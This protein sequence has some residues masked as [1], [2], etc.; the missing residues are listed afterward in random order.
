MKFYP[1]IQNEVEK[2]QYYAPKVEQFVRDQ[3]STFRFKL[4]ERAGIELPE[5]YV[6]DVAVQINDSIGT[7]VLKIPNALAS[8]LEWL[9]L[10]PLFLFFLLREGS[11]IKRSCL[12]LVPNAIFEKTYYL[13]SQ[14][15]KQISSYIFAKFVEA[16]I[17]GMIITLGLFFMEVRFAFILGIVAAV[18]NIIP[19]LGPILGTIPGIIVGFIDYGVSP[20]FGAVVVLYTVANIIDLALVFPILVS[21]IV[22]LHPVIVVV[23]VIIGSQYLGILGMVVSI[24]VAASLKLV[25]EEI[26]RDAHPYSAK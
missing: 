21:K 15:S 20:A 3:Y 22:N 17:I 7:L 18:T 10:V 25:V 8:F 1:T 14:F 16:A 23:S 11:S 5:E 24:P 6:D 2:L 19:Y 4:H 12:K 13:V 26:F 9:F